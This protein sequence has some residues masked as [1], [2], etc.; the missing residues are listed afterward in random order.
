MLNVLNV[1]HFINKNIKAIAIMLEIN[2]EKQLLFLLAVL[3]TL[4]RVELVTASK[5]SRLRLKHLRSEPTPRGQHPA[6]ISS[7]KSCEKYF[8]ILSRNLTLVI[9]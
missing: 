4:K 7:R 9:T 6:L 2:F 5:R 1:F 8:F 3:I